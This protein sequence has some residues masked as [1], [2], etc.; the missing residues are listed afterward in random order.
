[1]RLPSFKCRQI[2]GALLA[3][4]ALW[5]VA[6]P[7]GAI[8]LRQAYEAALEHDAQ[9]KVARAQRDAGLEERALGRSLLLPRLS[10]S[11]SDGRNRASSTGFESLA[12]AGSQA[13]SSSSEGTVRTQE[14]SNATRA[15]RPGETRQSTTERLINESAS[16]E[17]ELGVSSRQL[18]RERGPVTSAEG[19]I[20]LRQRL[21]DWSATAGYRQGVALSLASEADFRAA[22]QDLMVRVSEAFAAA[23]FEQ[24]NLRLARSQLET[25]EL[26]LA[27]NDRLLKAG[28]GTITDVLE[29][30]AKRELAS[31][32]LI[33]A[34]DALALARGRLALITG[35]P[36]AELIALREV[37]GRDLPAVQAFDHW[38]ELALMTNGAL[39]SGRH[40]V[41]AAREGARKAAAGHYP[42]LDLVVSVGTQRS[43]G[44]PTLWTES[45]GGS[46]RAVQS[47]SQSTTR[48]TTTTSGSLGGVAVSPVE[49]LTSTDRNTTGSIRSTD[50]SR[51][52]IGESGLRRNRSTDRYV[53]I[54]LTVPLFEGGA[55][56]ALSRQAAAQLARAEAERDG[57]MEALVLE[58]AQQHRLVNSAWQRIR[59]LSQ[60]VTSSRVTVEATSRSMAAGVRT[61]L[62]LLNALE[63]LAST[64][65]ELAGARYSY[66]LAYLRLRAIAGV[67]T[68]Q[69]LDTVSSPVQTP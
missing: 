9:I 10:A 58:L 68:P 49:T 32:A 24:E 21:L 7:A 66:W 19:V 22:E 69:D 25:L 52:S 56:S 43:R 37:E 44:L 63:R 33:E 65:R 13:S 29:T 14:S 64:E 50:S 8:S 20:E 51:S 34:E 48:D 61:N 5:S 1:M 2:P 11:F 46:Q 40:Q 45:E 36:A 38:R 15:G 53:G 59:A 55:T 31:A 4:F 26:Q 16:S 27:T 18:V 23:L 35:L 42:R 60:A 30:R 12:G 6:A 54:Q 39:Q 17:S 28:Q 62:D 47:A 67:L 41:D 57:L 3:L